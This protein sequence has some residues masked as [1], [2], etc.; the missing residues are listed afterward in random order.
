M[1]WGLMQEWDHVSVYLTSAE[2]SVRTIL[3]TGPHSWCW[4]VFYIKGIA[5]VSVQLRKAV[6]ANLF[7][8]WIQNHHLGKVSPNE[9]RGCWGIGFSCSWMVAHPSRMLFSLW[10]KNQLEW[11]RRQPISCWTEVTWE[12]GC[13]GV[14]A[15]SP[16]FH[17]RANV[18][19]SRL[20][21]KW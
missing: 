5:M 10:G 6:F 14:A 20:D 16:A 1:R 19:R 8:T 12:L 17:E 21:G 3:L 15:K 13:I 7:Y 18:K 2:S 4:T 9:W 11:N